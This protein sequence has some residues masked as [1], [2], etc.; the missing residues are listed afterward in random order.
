M[1]FSILWFVRLDRKLFAT[2]SHWEPFCIGKSSIIKKKKKKKTDQNRHRISQFYPPPTSITY[3]LKFVLFYLILICNL[4]FPD[5][6]LRVTNCTLWYF[7]MKTDFC[8]SI[9]YNDDIFYYCFFYDPGLFCNVNFF[10][11][12]VTQ[13]YQICLNF[14]LVAHDIVS[15]LVLLNVRSFL[16][17]FR[18]KL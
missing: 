10:K 14:M 16:R 5:E 6:S 12:Q 18:L 15:K 7:N 2:H 3:Y 4:I 8:K 13:F 11:I 9:F 1:V 17:R